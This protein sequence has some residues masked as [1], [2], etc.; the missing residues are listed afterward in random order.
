MTDQVD[1]DIQVLS[2]LVVRNDQGQFLLTKLNPELDRW[3]LPGADVEPFTHPDE[4]AQKILDGLGLVAES[5]E[6]KRVQSFRGRRGWHLSFD[7][8]VEASGRAHNPAQWFGLDA[9][10]QTMHGDWEVNLIKDLT[11]MDG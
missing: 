5:L 9:L 6:F 8:L 2:N 3:W 1:V 11:V 4:Q 7:Y 10:P